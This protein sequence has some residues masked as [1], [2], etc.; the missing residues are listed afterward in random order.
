MRGHCV[1][2]G[3]LCGRNGE[4]ADAHSSV[5]EFDDQRRW[6]ALE[7][8]YSG[9]GGAARVGP[10][11]QPHATA[12]R[13]ERHRHIWERALSYEFEVN[14]GATRLAAS[15]AISATSAAQTVWAVPANTL[16]LNKT[17]SW[18]ARATMGGVTVRGRHSPSAELNS[19]PIRFDKTVVEGNCV[20]A[21]STLEMCVMT[22]V[23]T[24]LIMSAAVVL[25]VGC[26]VK[27]SANP[28][29]PSIAGPVKGVVISTPNLL[30]PGQDWQLRTRDQPIKFLFQNADSN[31]ARPLK[32]SIDVAADSGFKIIVFARTGIEP[33]D[34]VTSLQLPDK[35]APGTYWWRTRAEDG[36]NTG[37]YSATKSFQVLQQVV[38][39]EPTPSAP[40][41]G[42]TIDGL[43]PEFRVKA[44]D[45]SGVTADLEYVLVV[46]NDSTFT[47]IAATF[48]QK[49]TWPET[50]N[51]PNYSF[52]YS[53]T[54][55]WRVRASHTGDGADSGPWSNIF[56]FK[57][58][59]PPPRGPDPGPNPDPG[60]LG[61]P[62]SCNSSK[63]SDIAEC[64]EA[65]Y[66]Q[67]RKAG[68]SL[69][70]RKA[71][72]QF[73]RNRLIEHATCKGLNVGLNLKRGGPDISNDFITYFTG[74]RWVGVDVSSGYDDTS[75]T[76]KMQWY[77]HGAG[78]NWGYPYH[79]PYGP[80]SCN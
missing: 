23:C 12:L 50:R 3:G 62:A 26:H 43:I 17:Y 16:K 4:G 7:G 46:S 35:L 75:T 41:N 25:L 47:S 34:G 1:R 10:S 76:L 14:E 45:R 61:N 15:A 42:T 80:V 19:L 21:A 5:D 57:T 63:G 69:D 77:Q 13:G 24:R 31:G 9:A 27:K 2:G 66:P 58:P 37:P 32:Y 48:T 64:I 53:K 55:Y 6:H 68:V 8:D 65:R 33:G 30:E 59:A 71:N 70:Q 22:R 40:S 60:P 56:T 49:E 44:G 72:M 73:L 18:R 36:A 29:S 51:E 74:G 67:Y 78:T 79:Q 20:Q 11:H 54:Y 38:L 52:L 28:L 39:G